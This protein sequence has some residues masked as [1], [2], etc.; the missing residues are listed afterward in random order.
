[1]VQV[2][3]GIGDV[4]ATWAIRSTDVAVVGSCAAC[5]ESFED[6]LGHSQGYKCG[7]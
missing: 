3:W 7:R 5:R 1:M 4:V 6:A 2:A